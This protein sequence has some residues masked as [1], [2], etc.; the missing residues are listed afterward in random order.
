MGRYMGQFGNDAYTF[1]N[2]VK[3]GKPNL[4]NNSKYFVRNGESI[5]T[6]QWFLGNTQLITRTPQDSYEE[7]LRHFDKSND[8]SSML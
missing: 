3:S 1:E 2:Q 6:T 7:L 5:A 4:F 8:K